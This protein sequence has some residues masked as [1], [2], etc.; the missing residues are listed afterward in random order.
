MVS[1]I[2]KKIAKSLARFYAKKE[3]KLNDTWFF[4]KIECEVLKSIKISNHAAKRIAQRFESSQQEILAGAISRAIRAIPT[5]NSNHHISK[6]IKY[7]DKL[8]GIV[9]V[10][11]RLGL[12]GANI[13]TVW[14]DT[15]EYAKVIND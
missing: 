9:V 14:D 15:K 3:K 8:T 1:I 4:K 6:S 11:E 12:S 7:K 5:D 2:A 10:L 13:V